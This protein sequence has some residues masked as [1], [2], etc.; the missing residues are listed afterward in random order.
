MPK[1]SV[2]M[3]VY[4]AQAYLSKAVESILQQTWN[5][6]EFIIID[7][8]SMDDGPRMLADYANQDARI[9]LHTNASNLG[10]TKSLNLGLKMAQ[11][12]YIARQDA[13]D[14]SL[15]SR[16]SLQH[17][18]LE[19]DPT[20]QL[21]GSNVEMI[22][23][24]GDSIGKQTRAA[25][26]GMIDWWM[27]FYNYIGAH[28]AVMMRREQVLAI[29]G[30]DEAY[31]YSQDYELWLRLRQYG[32]LAILPRTLLQLRNHDQNISS[33]KKAEQ[34]QLSLACSHQAL[35]A[36]LGKEIGLEEVEILRGFWIEPY[37]PHQMM[38]IIQRRLLQIYHAFL[39]RYP[40]HTPLEDKI[41]QTI[42]NQWVRWAR[43]ISIRR[44]PAPKL[45]MLSNAAV[46][47]PGS[48]LEELQHHL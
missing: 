3:S 17:S 6:L 19:S 4:N 40:Q 1:I 43:A 44:T 27:P 18:H 2:L 15:P 45:A 22:S 25:D 9:R 46:W 31:P 36:L 11:G 29:G 24:A 42:G 8:A 26:S 16:L 33:Q 35:T 30:Y 39:R 13:D 48:L 34:D 7:D 38:A 37:P 20:C 47:Y 10:L 21:V 12:E 5:D 14:I 23:E 32:E 28:S 41:K